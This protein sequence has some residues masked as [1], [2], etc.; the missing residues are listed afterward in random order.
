LFIGHYAAGLVGKSIDRRVPLWHL[1]VAAQLVDFVWAA[2]V[3][4]GVEKVRIVDGFSAA[5]PLDLHYFPYSHSLPAVVALAA[6]ATLA[7]RSIGSWR[8]ALIIG[9]VVLSHWVADWLVHT[10]D[11]PL[12]ADQHKVGLGLWD[13]LAAAMTVEIGCMVGAL[14]LYLRATEPAT[15]AGRY[16]M[17]V[18]AAAMVAMFVGGT[19]GSPPPSSTA[20]AGMGLFSFV[21]FAAVAGWL[22]RKRS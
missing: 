3:L 16:A 6:V 15:P 18:F 14:L 11:L 1:F 22:D 8:S 19:L 7:Y 12:F 9:A 21:G 5:S 2:L 20:L 17:P 10:P 4:I 13:N